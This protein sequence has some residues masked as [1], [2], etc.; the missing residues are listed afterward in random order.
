MRRAWIKEKNARVGL[1]AAK[2]TAASER[3]STDAM[4]KNVT[5][6]MIAG[7]M[8]MRPSSVLGEYSP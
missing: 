8:N 5:P 4:E 2:R 7:M 3:T 1:V 6:P